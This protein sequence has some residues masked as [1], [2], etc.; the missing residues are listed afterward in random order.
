MRIDLIINV[1]QTQFRA[2]IMMRESTFNSFHAI[3]SDISATTREVKVVSI[4]YPL[5]RLVQYFE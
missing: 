4:Y 5:L 1:S 3:L 2:C